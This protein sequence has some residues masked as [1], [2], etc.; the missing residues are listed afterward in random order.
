MQPDPLDLSEVRGQEVAK[1]VLEVAAA[2]NHH[3]LL[4]GPPGTGKTMLAVRLAGLLPPLLPAEAAEVAEIYRLRPDAGAASGPARPFRRPPP[5]TTPAAMIGGGAHPRPGEA[6]L[7]HLGVLF[8][9]ELSS[10]RP[11]TLACLLQPMTDGQVE[12]SGSRRSGS[13]PARFLFV[14]AMNPCPCGWRGHGE[15]H[16]SPGLVARHQRPVTGALRDRIHLRVEIPPVCLAELRSSAGESSATVAA[17]VAFAREVQ[18]S[19]SGQ[20]NGTL[21]HAALRLHATL[22]AAGESLLGL[23]TEKLGL[24]ARCRAQLLGIARTVADIAG[25][26]VVRPSHLSEAIQYV[27]CRWHAAASAYQPGV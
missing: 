24:S 11:D 20:L 23:A 12:V 19:R 4:A 2:G 18:L 25:S 9:D 14:G 8:L 7:A 22:D 5:R 10:F 6:S 16:C 3:L 21:S 13:F 27:A 17:R 15:C 26:D 1:R